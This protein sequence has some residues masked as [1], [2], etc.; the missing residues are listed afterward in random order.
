[1]RIQILHDAFVLIDDLLATPHH[2]LLFPGG[3]F[4]VNISIAVPA[5]SVL[6]SYSHFVWALIVDPAPTDALIRQYWEARAMQPARTADQFLL[7][8]DPEDPGLLLLPHYC[9][10]PLAVHPWSQFSLEFDAVEA[11][12][13]QLV[14]EGF[15]SW[16]DVAEHPWKTQLPIASLQRLVAYSIF[17]RDL[18]IEQVLEFVRLCIPLTG[19]DESPVFPLHHNLRPARIDAI[20]SEGTHSEFPGFSLIRPGEVGLLDAF[21]AWG[22]GR[23]VEQWDPLRVT[24]LQ[25]LPLDQPIQILRQV[26]KNHYFE[27][28]GV[29]SFA[30]IRGVTGDLGFLETYL[31]AVAINDLGLIDTEAKLVVPGIPNVGI[32]EGVRAMQDLF[33]DTYAALQLATES[34]HPDHEI[35][36]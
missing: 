12:L 22:L 24:L 15:Q 10:S 7:E 35:T 8:T 1:M 16:H 27:H 18:D 33:T 3:Q 32:F 31:A 13:F 20:V 21:L 26:V 11:D 28:Q 25:T 5:D 17:L 4:P 9:R 23:I 30:V 29:P 6:F 36:K 14:R 19:S 2:Q 34:S